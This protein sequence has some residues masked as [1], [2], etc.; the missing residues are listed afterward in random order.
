MR[1]TAVQHAGLRASAAVGLVGRLEFDNSSTA[2]V[3]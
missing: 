1:N 3:F 2:D